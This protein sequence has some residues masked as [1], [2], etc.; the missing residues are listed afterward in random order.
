M[1]PRLVQVFHT[2]HKNAL[3]Q[4]VMQRRKQLDAAARQEKSARIT[5]ALLQ[6]L[7]ADSGGNAHVLAY[8]AMNSEV[9]I[10]PVF[11]RADR[12]HVYAPVTHHHEHMQWHRIT[13]DTQWRKGLFGI[14]EPVDGELWNP[15]EYP[16]VLVCP[17]TGFDRKGNRLGM[18]KGCFDFWLA[19]HRRHIARII[20]VG[21]ACQELE[22]IPAEPHDIP[23]QII[24]TENEVIHV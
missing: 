13:A 19:R 5:S 14:Y 4:T 21:F 12:Q 6:L 23:M 15:G 10:D 1:F 3:R 9:N 22:R 20:G 18:G 24:I 17:L 8:R 7:D 16:T 11:E 2:M